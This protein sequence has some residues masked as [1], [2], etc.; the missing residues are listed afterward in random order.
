MDE[1]LSWEDRYKQLEAHHL[2]ET[3]FLIESIKQMKTNEIYPHTNSSP[4]VPFAREP[5]EKVGLVTRFHRFNRSIRDKVMAAH[6]WDRLIHFIDYLGH[7]VIEG[8]SHEKALEYA[9]TDAWPMILFFMLPITILVGTAKLC[10]YIPY[11][12]V[13]GLKKIVSLILFGKES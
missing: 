5:V 4:V 1:S 9:S 6:P 13:S 2:E 8:R 7:R 11:W 3:S 10:V 12:I